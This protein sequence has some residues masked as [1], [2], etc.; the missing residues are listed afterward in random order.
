MTLELSALTG[1]GVNPHSYRSGTDNLFEK[2][3]AGFADKRDLKLSA[4]LPDE[5]QIFLSIYMSV[6]KKKLGRVSLAVHVNIIEWKGE[7]LKSKNG[8][9]RVN[10]AFNLNSKSTCL[11][12]W[13]VISRL[14]SYHLSCNNIYIAYKISFWSGHMLLPS[15]LSFTENVSAR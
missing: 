9:I 1:R 2:S 11:R 3:A 5:S 8:L 15:C 13:K 6:M 10:Q 12:N 4:F 7:R 14:R